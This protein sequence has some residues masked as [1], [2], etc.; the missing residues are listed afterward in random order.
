MINFACL[1][2]I[3]LI[4][5]VILICSCDYYVVNSYKHDI[6][7]L[8]PSKALDKGFKACYEE[9]ILEPYFSRNIPA[10]F[11]HGK[12]S[13][14]S[15]FLKHYDHKGIVNESGYIT[16]RFI[17]NCEGEAGRFIR[18]GVGSDYEKKQFH[19]E[20]TSQLYALLAELKD[21]R[22]LQIGDVILDSHIYITF[23]IESGELVEILP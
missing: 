13:L 14:R 16:F 11:E 3:L 7:Y 15:Y 21:W 20:L 4:L 10:G 6:G 1:G 23:K 17:I 19:P 22:A 2:R 9:N 12:D 8:D 5:S 18:Y